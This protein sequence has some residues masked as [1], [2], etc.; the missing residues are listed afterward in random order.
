MAF[1]PLSEQEI[2]T[3]LISTY[4]SLLTATD[5]L[6]TGSVVR[7]LLESYALDV[8]TLY[9]N[10]AVAALELQRTAAYSIF[11]FPLLQPQAA[12]TMEQFA[13]TPVPTVA[14]NIPAGTTVEIQ[15]TTIPYQTVADTI[16]PAN[17]ANVL[18]RVVC[19]QAGVI[20]NT[21]AN[22]ITQLVS[23]IVGLQGVTVTN[24]QAVISGRDLETDQA[25]AQRFTQFLRTIHRGDVAALKYGAKTTQLLDSYG[26]ISEQVLKA[27]VVEGNGAN[28]IYIDNGTYNT[29]TPLV[30]QCQ[31]I[32][33]GY[34]DTNNNYI[35]GYKAA[36]IPSTVQAAPVQAV[37]ITIAVTP[38]TGY[39]LAMIQQTITDSINTLVNSLDVGDTLYVQSLNVA[40]GNVPGVLT[41]TLSSPAA[42]V[43]PAAGTI[44]QLPVNNL[45]ITQK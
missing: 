33:N 3:N 4:L 31:Q 40:I 9:V 24:T 1:T 6:N 29:S 20:G 12:Y 38:N 36:G 11:S 17:A 45:T 42:D 8:K 19:T 30:T 34:V 2:L 37:T 43:V 27:Q 26:Y 21:S 25:R 13:A 10:M 15:G 16:Y 32:I 7:S 18:V 28:T 41:F 35:I 44:L 5:D 22:T 23:P 14:T 39:T